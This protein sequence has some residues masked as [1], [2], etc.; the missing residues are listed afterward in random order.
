MLKH[1]IEREYEKENKG[2]PVVVQMFQSV[3]CTSWF[4]WLT[5]AAAVTAARSKGTIIQ[6]MP[7]KH[8][9]PEVFAVQTANG[10]PLLLAF[11]SGAI[12]KQQG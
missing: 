1:E 11:P 3:L 6:P 4:S 2:L 12:H 10:P 5:A 9:R 7:K 8:F